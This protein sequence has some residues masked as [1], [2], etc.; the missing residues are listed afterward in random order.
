VLQL[1]YFGQINFGLKGFEELD[2]NAKELLKIL[3][4]IILNKEN[5]R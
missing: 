1:Q 2:S 3:K 4:K 5:T